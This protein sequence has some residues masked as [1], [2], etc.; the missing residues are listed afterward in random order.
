[1][2]GLTNFFTAPGVTALFGVVVGISLKGLFDVLGDHRRLQYEARERREQREHEAAMQQEEARDRRIRAYARFLGMAHT[3]GHWRRHQEVM[4]TGEELRDLAESYAETDVVAR[5]EE[6]RTAA[7]HI[8]GSALQGS[9]DI[10]DT[11]D[12]VSAIRREEAEED[13]Q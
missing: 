12:F 2:Q 3:V 11:D 13:D 4:P 10:I 5:T 6:V 9:E 7:Y 8:F 1:M